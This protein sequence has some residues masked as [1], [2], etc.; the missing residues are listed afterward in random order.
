MLD[1]KP[2]ELSDRGGILRHVIKKPV[3]R[4]T[5]N[6]GA[7][8]KAHLIGSYEGRVFDERDVDFVIGEVDEDDIIAGVQTGLT[9]FGRGETSR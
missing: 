3:T 2:E 1:W 9:H 5:P 4:K 7:S 8:V 6:D